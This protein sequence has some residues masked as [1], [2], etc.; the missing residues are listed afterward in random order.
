MTILITGGASG[1]GE[2]ITRKL[3]TQSNHTI[4]FTYNHSIDKAKQIEQDYPN[5]KA[6]HCDFLNPDSIGSLLEYIENSSIDILI[7]NAFATAIHAQHFH[8]IPVT[9][10]TGNFLSNII[11]TILITQKAIAQFRKNKFGKII[12]VLSSA[13]IDT[14]PVGWSEYTAEKAY[15]AS[16][17]KSW[18]TENSAFNISAN[19]ISPAFMLT[20]L[21]KDTDERMVESI[22]NAHPLKKILAT[23][24]VADAV[25]FLTNCSQQINGTNMIIN[26]GAHV[27]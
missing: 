23:D 22:T 8:K 20:D 12:T 26:A 11:P 7:N 9:T 17:S 18:A 24:E 14:P 6:I 21:T 10:F 1:L 15:L 13:I 25:S 4:L 3:A 16:M 2:A 27:I 5:T 19:A